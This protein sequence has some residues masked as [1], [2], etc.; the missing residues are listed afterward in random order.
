MSETKKHIFKAPDDISGRDIKKPSVFLAGSIDQGN[1][2]DWQVR[3]TNALGSDY[4]IF[5]PR[6][7]DWDDTWDVSFNNSNFYQQV[8]WELDCLDTA[9]VIAMYF[10]DH[11]KSPI[12]LLEL[13]LYATPRY[14]DYEVSPSKLVV[15]CNDFYRKGNI[16]VVCSRFGIPVFNDYDTWLVE[17]KRRLKNETRLFLQ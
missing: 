17:L 16:D 8:T 10:A 14:N 12:T 4:N 7:D 11:S 15:Y 5:N 13:G 1:A 6:R 2:V 3:V 9:D